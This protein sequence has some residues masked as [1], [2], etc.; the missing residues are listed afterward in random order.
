MAP[1]PV[2]DT[3]LDEVPA[4]EAD[5]TDL[6]ELQRSIELMQDTGAL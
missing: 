6:E 4:P 1:D 2:L 5:I 3:P